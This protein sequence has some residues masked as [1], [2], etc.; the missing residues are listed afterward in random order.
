MSHRDDREHVQSLLA[1]VARRSDAAPVVEA[2]RA[3]LSR[4]DLGFVTG[5]GL[6]LAARCTDPRAAA[7]LD[8][9]QRLFELVAATPGPEHAALAL[10]LLAMLPPGPRRHTRHQASVLA[11]DR[12]ATDL[13]AAFS[14]PAAE[15][16]RLALVREL[17][18]RGTDPAGVP[19]IAAWLDHRRRTRR[20]LQSATAPGTAPLPRFGAPARE[21]CLGPNDGGPL[22]PIGPA[23]PCPPVEEVT[24]RETADALGS[25]TARWS[26]GSN[27]RTEARVFRFRAP[28]AAPATA[29]TPGLL[30][31][32]LPG[33]ALDCLDHSPGPRS[34]RRRTR[35]PAGLA[36][37]AVE[38]EQVWDLLHAAATGGGAYSRGLDEASGRLAAWRSLAALADCPGTATT[39]EVE[40]AADEHLWFSF[41]SDSPWFGQVAWDLG[42]L[43][44]SPDLRRLAVLAATDTD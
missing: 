2:T 11:A 42:V 16:L 21:L 15:R 8:A 43:S 40:L 5:L 30:R 26:S 35:H 17:E 44:L 31:T 27:G 38:A 3:A 23:A 10:G 32:A 12:P 34:N 25:A 6:A 33:L 9:F 13:A 20:P 39:D 7:Q 24:D 41:E 28:L 22:P 18:L 4:G 14:G 37:R 19:E 36:V 1:R 29:L